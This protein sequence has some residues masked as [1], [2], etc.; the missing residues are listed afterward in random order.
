MN[1]LFKKIAVICLIAM[2]LFSSTAQALVMPSTSTPVGR[3]IA[4]AMAARGAAPGL[5]RVMSGL[6]P[7][8]LIAGLLLPVV[9]D[10]ALSDDKQTVTYTPPGSGGPSG[11]NFRGNTYNNQ[12]VAGGDAISVGVAIIYYNTCN[13]FSGCPGFSFGAPYEV[14]SY[15]TGPV[16]HVIAMDQNPSGSPIQRSATVQDFGQAYTGTPAY[17]PPT[18]PQPKTVPVHD[19]IP[20]LPQAMKD[21]PITAKQMADLINRILD[22]DRAVN[23]AK[24][25]NDTAANPVTEAQIQALR[26]VTGETPKVG[27]LASPTGFPKPED[28]KN[29]Y[30]NTPIQNPSAPITPSGIDWTIQGNTESVQKQSVP[31]SYT[32]T[33]FAAPTG[34]PAPIPFAMF[35]TTYNISWQPA[36]DLMATLAPIFLATGAAAGA[37]IFARSLKS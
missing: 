19:A 4:A 7:Y 32:P 1:M 3:E 21:Q 26:Q 30:E 24:P 31:V 35:G 2:Y 11:T 29:P 8:G 28:V 15:G 14:T 22:D 33:I 6:G 13:S 36:C 12:I 27:D 17:S 18:A 20:D 10:W 23:G 9:I 25:Y 34:C 16:A 5:G 37:L